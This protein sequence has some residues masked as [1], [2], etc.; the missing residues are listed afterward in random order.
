MFLVACDRISVHRIG[1]TV[2]SHEPDVS[3]IVALDHNEVALAHAVAD[4][5]GGWNS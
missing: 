1:Q 3:R 5:C 4:E 2:D